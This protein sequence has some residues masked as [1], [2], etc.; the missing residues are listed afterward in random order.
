MDEAK[1]RRNDKLTVLIASCDKHA[2][3]WG[4]FSALWKKFWPDCP[5]EVALA[6]ESPAENSPDFCFGRIIPCTRERNWSIFLS[7]ALR[8]I[9][10]PYVILLC[11]D[12][13]LCDRVDTA[14]VASLI[15][16]AERF[17]IGYLPM[18]PAAPGRPVFE[19]DDRLAVYEKGRAYCIGLQAGIWDVRFLQFLADQEY[20]SIWQFE[21]RAGFKAAESDFLLAGTRRR[22]FPFI[23]A[24][25]KGYWEKAGLALCR[26]NGAPV[27]LRKRGLPPFPAR[28]VK[29]GGK[30]LFRLF[31]AELI[32]RI[33]NRIYSLPRGKGGRP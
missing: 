32:V 21:R 27:D 5:F 16:L 4:P 3:L 18:I 11:D 6:T 30:A 33:Q 24:V 29:W 8:E 7:T 17:H 28:L 22:A 23:D 19:G 14:T 10:T 31:G 25:H 12:Y 13:F 1:D 9:R 2:D 15:P 20:P 26:E